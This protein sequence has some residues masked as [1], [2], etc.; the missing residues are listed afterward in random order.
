LG[1]H[2]DYYFRKKRVSSNVIYSV[3][4]PVLLDPPKTVYQSIHN[5]RI[6]CDR[7]D[8]A[9]RLC[10]PKQLLLRIDLVIRGSR[11]NLRGLRGK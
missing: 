10:A 6:K 9:L 2:D 7:D 3:V 1:H 11:G 4:S 5:S 8:V